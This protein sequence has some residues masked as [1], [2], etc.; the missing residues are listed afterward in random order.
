MTPTDF[1]AEELALWE[2]ALRDQ[3]RAEE[4]FKAAHIRGPSRCGV[5]L[6]RELHARRTKA[7]LL[8]AKAVKVKCAFRDRVF[9]DEVSDSTMPGGLGRMG[10]A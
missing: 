8:L 10:A 9:Y 7:D 6:M 3:K 2:Q 4:D 1:A 5:E